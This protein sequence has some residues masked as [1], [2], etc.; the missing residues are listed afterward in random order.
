VPVR[1]QQLHCADAEIRELM[2]ALRA[3]GPMPARGVAVA[4]RLLTDGRGPIYNPN[5]PDD[6]AATLRFAIE[7]LDPALP[8]VS[9]G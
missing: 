2:E 3:T 5:A 6:L 1:R 4:A 9:T 7:Q 8:L